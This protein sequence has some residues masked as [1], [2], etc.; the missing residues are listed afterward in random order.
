MEKLHLF[1][2]IEP[3]DE[4]LHLEQEMESELMYG[5]IDTNIMVNGKITLWIEVVPIHIQIETNL[6]ES[7]KIEKNI[8]ELL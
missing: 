2:R 6:N 7:L 8:V 3:I 5:Q 4:I 1:M